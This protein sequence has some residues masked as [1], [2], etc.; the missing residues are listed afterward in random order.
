M[1]RFR[2]LV[3]SI[4]IF[5]LLHIPTFSQV[6]NVK[7]YVI[8]KYS[9]DAIPYATC[10]LLNKGKGFVANENGYIAFSY[11]KVIDSLKISS[12]GYEARV[13]RF[14]VYSD[15]II[16][17]GLDAIKIGE[18]KVY[19]DRK[20]NL[21]KAQSG[22]I[23][24][25]LL[26][27]ESVPKFFGESDLLKS[28]MI[29]P[30]VASTLDGYSSLLIR[31][32]NADQNLYLID[33]C[34]VFNIN[35]LGGFVSLFN[36]NALKYV[37]VYKNSFP[38]HLGGKTSGILDVKTRD[39]NRYNY[40]GE[41]SLGIVSSGLLVEGPIIKNKMVFLTSFRTSYFD[42]INKALNSDNESYFNYRFH[43]LNTKISYY[44]PNNSK[45][46]LSFY[47][48]ADFMKNYDEGGIF[49]SLGISEKNI[50]ISTNNQKNR[51]A[52]IGF[53]GNIGST[54]L[55]ATSYISNYTQLN[56]EHDEVIIT[57]TYST[58]DA[59]MNIGITKYGIKLISEQP[60]NG[61][62]DKIITSIETGWY[63]IMPG[64]YNR[65]EFSS[66]DSFTR[67]SN[68]GKHYSGYPSELSLSVESRNKLLNNKLEVGFGIRASRFNNDFG[69]KFSDLEPR[70]SVS[71][72]V[73]NISHIAAS[74]TQMNQYIHG[75]VNNIDGFERIHWFAADNILLPQHSEQ[76]SLSFNSVLKRA[77]IDLTTELFYKKSKNLPLIKPI[78]SNADFQNFWTDRFD[79]SGIGYSYGIEILLKKQTSK[80]MGILS[81]T[82]QRSFRKFETL[83]NGDWFP[84]DFD[85]PHNLNFLLQYNGKNNITYK[86]TFILRSG[87]PINLPSGY[88][89]S[90]LF[91]GYSTF[92]GYNNYR[93]PVY[94]RLDLAIERNWKTSNGNNFTFFV[95]V[96]NVYARINPTSIE[97]SDNKL[98][99]L[100][101]FTI[102][103]S[104]GIKFRF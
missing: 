71:Y 22:K 66:I 13:V 50:D 96:F 21:L 37:D 2:Y 76:Y 73:S 61:G 51:I 97:I 12:V 70:F 92:N 74:Y 77:D 40:H 18:V 49:T 25:P 67:F 44:L 28:L 58:I 103:P 30:G 48:G 38:S 88:A 29:Y 83:N 15:T 5:M 32:G 9:G 14:E 102:I 19:G 91:W 101:Y 80:F 34:P 6:Y 16:K 23:T 86:S 81:Y 45:L 95:S 98:K 59:K 33:D 47:D 42:L 63:S 65:I 68:I 4:V 24:V 3:T 41:L 90:S 60:Y 79:P 94:H 82:Y 85:R 64:E 89:S 26:S 78:Q 75:L 20:L 27:L 52:S 17:I 54:T 11:S 87:T 100:S 99:G 69:N 31:G 93:L 55:L 1:N 7:L 57:P 53:K 35:H 8:N 46:Y 56:K 104:A 43:D 84:Y 62:E 10:Q 36:T 39:G 72:F